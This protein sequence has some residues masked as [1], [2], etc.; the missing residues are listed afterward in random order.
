MEEVIRQYITQQPMGCREVQFVW[1]GGEPMLAGL[2]FYQKAIELQHKYARPG[3]HITNAM[4][5]NGTLLNRR[6]AEFLKQHDFLVGI[7]IDGDKQNHDQQRLYFS[8]KPSF[9][10]VMRGLRYLMELEVRFNVLSVVHNDNVHLARQT[11]E[12]LLSKGV[13]SIQYLPDTLNHI[14][15]NAWGRFLIETFQSW[16][17]DG[18]G[19]VT[20]QLFD[21]TFTRVHTNFE[22]FCVH[23]KQCG[24]QLAVERG[25][26]VYSC[27]HFVEPEYRLG[28]I[29]DSDFVSMMESEPHRKFATNSVTSHDDCMSCCVRGVCQGGCPRHRDIGDKNQLCDGYK[30]FFRYSAPY[31]LAMSE[32]LRRRLPPTQ[33][34]QFLPLTKLSFV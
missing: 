6:W 14:D 23:A 21:A 13:K 27:D 25:G 26:E 5:T 9:D 17:K 11:Y 7:S 2:E 29:G 8:G 1:Q 4:Q 24:H 16:L 3:M 15:A 20:V 28:R 18:V 22:T 31:F 12:F 10:N 19:Q 32:C 30:Q 34:K 33:Y